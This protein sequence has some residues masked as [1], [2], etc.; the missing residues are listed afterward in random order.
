M[1]R[2]GG[3]QAPRNVSRGQSQGVTQRASSCPVS[4]KFA[5]TNPRVQWFQLYTPGSA[6]DQGSSFW[7]TLKAACG[8]Q[9]KTRKGISNFFSN[10]LLTR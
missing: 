1:D 8:T 10:H 7:T 5:V 4:L 6:W 9:K 2:R 3:A